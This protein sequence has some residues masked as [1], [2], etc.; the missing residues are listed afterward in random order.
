MD[1]NL[2]F[3]KRTFSGL[4]AVLVV[5]RRMAFVRQPSLMGRPIR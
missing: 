4:H 5:E 3:Q 2:K 1:G